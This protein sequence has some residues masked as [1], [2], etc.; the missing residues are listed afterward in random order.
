[1]T[2]KIEL[3]EQEIAT[4]LWSLIRNRQYI[5]KVLKTGKEGSYKLTKNSR[6]NTQR[7]LKNV[8]NLEKFFDK[9]NEELV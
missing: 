9:L 3:N 6:E 1:M 2:K 4:I 8:A 5:E 7:D